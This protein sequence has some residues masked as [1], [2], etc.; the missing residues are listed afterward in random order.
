MSLNFC[1]IVLGI[2]PL[3]SAPEFYHTKPLQSASSSHVCF[4]SRPS[5]TSG[6]TSRRLR[7]LDIEESPPLDLVEKQWAVE[8]SLRRTS[9]QKSER[10]DNSASDSEAMIKQIE[11]PS[12]KSMPHLCRKE[13]S[14]DNSHSSVKKTK[15]DVWGRS[16]YRSRRRK[17]NSHYMSPVTISDARF[18]DTD[19]YDVP[20][21]MSGNKLV[22]SSQSSGKSHDNVESSTEGRRGSISNG[23]QLHDNCE[24][25]C[26]DSQ[27]S[28][29]SRIRHTSGKSPERLQLSKSPERHSLPKSADIKN[30]VNEL[31]PPILKPM[32]L[33]SDKNP[34]VSQKSSEKLFDLTVNI[35]DI[36]NKSLLGKISPKAAV[37]K[38][39]E[40]D[41]GISSS[42][43]SN[44]DSVDSIENA[45]QL[46][47][48]VSLQI[49]MENV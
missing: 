33:P 25:S 10:G 41:S 45:K 1:F 26:K 12:K 5:E 32:N 43:D 2:D 49:W 17:R 46:A 27:T 7:G 20:D 19:D 29:K 18:S 13:G 30:T 3:K 23:S 31:G 37:V 4:S 6:R 21:I 24:L 44:G 40:T 15:K 39:M 14:G 8:K 48:Q 36:S 9:P 22:Q 35:E 11:N 34:S 42:V 28:S 16:S 47:K 38:S